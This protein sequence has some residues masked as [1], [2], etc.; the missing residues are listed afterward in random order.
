MRTVL[1]WIIYGIIPQSPWALRMLL[2]A[3]GMVSWLAGVMFLSVLW[4]DRLDAAAG[5]FTQWVEE[6]CLGKKSL[7]GSVRRDTSSMRVDVT[8]AENGVGVW[9]GKLSPV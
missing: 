6:V 2:G 3:I 8:K 5:V 4:R 7:M 1:V 9:K